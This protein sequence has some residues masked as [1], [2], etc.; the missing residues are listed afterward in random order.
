MTPAATE[1][2]AIPRPG[3]LATVRNRRGTVTA[4]DPFDGETGRLH[5]VQL[6]YQDGGSPSA[7]RL[8]WELEPR[9]T[10]LE[11]TALPDPYVADP[12]PHSGLRRASAGRSLDSALSL[13]R[14]GRQGPERRSGAN[15]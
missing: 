2:N 8:L 4:V 3:M 1:G 11:P 6:D 13:H 9:K 10:L 12:M 14:P 7:E 15:R 5:L